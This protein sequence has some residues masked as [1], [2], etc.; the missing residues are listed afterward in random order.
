MKK[1]KLG[2][3]ISIIIIGLIITLYAALWIYLGL[4][5][6]CLILL[7]PLICLIKVGIDRFKEIEEEKDDIS[8]Y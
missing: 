2:V 3:I 4:W 6:V 8:K 1:Q 5:Y 7:I